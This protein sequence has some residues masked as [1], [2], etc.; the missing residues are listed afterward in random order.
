M[1]GRN[2]DH[3]VDEDVGKL[4]VRR[5]TVVAAAAEAVGHP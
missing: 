4:G 2:R 1:T 3:F 5:V